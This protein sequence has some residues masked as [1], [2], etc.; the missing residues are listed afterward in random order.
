MDVLV[1]LI[2]LDEG[3]ARARQFEFDGQSSLTRGPGQLRP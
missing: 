3:K 2:G 1:R